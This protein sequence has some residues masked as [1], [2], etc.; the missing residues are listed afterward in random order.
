MN[1]AQFCELKLGWNPD[2]PR[3]EGG[4]F[5]SGDGSQH[6]SKE[7]DE[8]GA[9]EERAAQGKALKNAL[10]K[11]A[12]KRSGPTRISGKTA[13]EDAI[14]TLKEFSKPGSIANLN[15]DAQ[16]SM[17]K[18]LAEQ[19]K[20]HGLNRDGSENALMKDAESRAAKAAPKKTA[21]YAGSLGSKEEAEAL[22]SKF[23]GATVKEKKNGYGQ[24]MSYDVHSKD[25]DSNTEVMKAVYAHKTKAK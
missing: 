24:I 2:Q 1:I 5:A 20:E 18:Y 23:P 9:G 3:D 4:R 22:A 21:T 17:N 25:G 11:D 7:S 19:M 12:E 8:K 13:K 15:P 10:I 16:Q 14:D 6:G